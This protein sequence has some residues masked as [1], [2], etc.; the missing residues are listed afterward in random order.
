MGKEITIIGTHSMQVIETL[1]IDLVSQDYSSV[2]VVYNEDE[3]ITNLK[4]RPTHDIPNGLVGDSLIGYL[5]S[6]DGVCR[7]HGD[8]CDEIIN[9]FEWIIYQDNGYGFEIYCYDDNCDNCPTC[10]AFVVNDDCEHDVRAL[11][12]KWGLQ[13]WKECEL[14][15]GLTTMF[16]NN[17]DDHVSFDT[18]LKKQ[19]IKKLQTEIINK[20]E[21]GFDEVSSSAV[22]I[23]AKDAKHLDPKTR[24]LLVEEVANIAVGLGPLEKIFADSEISE[25][26]INGYESIYIE[27]NG[28]LK[29]LS[30]S[31]A[32]KE[33][34]FSLID[35]LLMDSG[36]RIDES[37]PLVDARLNDGSRVNVIIPPLALDGPSVTIRRFPNRRFCLNDLVSNGTLNKKIAEYLSH[38]IENKQNIIISGGTGTGKTTFLNAVSGCISPSER[39]VTIEDAAEI[40]LQQEHVIRLESRL[41][42]IEGKG[43]V[44][45]RDLL[46][47]ALRMRPDRIII[48]E[49]R[50]AEALDMMQA[51]STGHDG[52]MT[53]VHANSARDAL[54]RIETMVM[55]SGVDLPWRGIRQQLARAVDMVVH[56]AR[57]SD[58]SRV[59][60]EMLEITGMEGDV[61]TA[62]EVFDGEDRCD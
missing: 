33:E 7:C 3:N 61:I 36:R 37:T 32:D 18:A 52:S 49:C 2:L 56:L 55:F 41:A 59:V 58:G 20:N 29:K 44:T 9:S 27:K 30:G 46:K 34:M 43:A 15:D 25:V 14:A 28:K 51:M 22:E 13:V 1:A 23:I 54:I 57:K 42:N 45:A 4:V 19:I 35:R 6:E 39:I 5:Q 50:G 12:S 21:F 48:G 24:K 62:N 26:M 53:T 38:S 16:T 60:T 17:D 31:I 11:E 8:F 40:F 47:N 10:N